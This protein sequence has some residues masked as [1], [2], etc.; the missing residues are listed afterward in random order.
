MA[1]SSTDV[2]NVAPELS[3]TESGRMNWAV[4]VANGRFSN[5]VLGEPKANLARAYYA[6]HLLSL[7]DAGARGGVVSESMGGISRTFTTRNAQGSDLESTSYGAA[8]KAI[9]RGHGLRAGLVGG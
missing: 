2:Q 1:I 6:A 5:D 3:S 9:L 8:C 4:G 7:G